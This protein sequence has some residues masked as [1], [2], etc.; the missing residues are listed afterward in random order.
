MGAG[1]VG[2][3]AVN[4]AGGGQISGIGVGPSGEPGVDLRKKH[5]NPLLF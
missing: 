2:G 4:N 5:F 3:V 1:A